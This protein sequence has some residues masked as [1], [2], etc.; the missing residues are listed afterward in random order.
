MDLKGTGAIVEASESRTLEPTTTQHALAPTQS[1]SLFA[2]DIGRFVNKSSSLDSNSKLRL[3]KSPWTP[4]VSYIFPVSEKR[5]LKFQL[6]W[7]ARF[8]WLSYSPSEDAAFCRFCVL[9]SSETAGKGCHQ[10]LGNLVTKPFRN[11]KDAIECFTAH[12]Q[13]QFHRNC[14]VSAENFISVSEKRQDN[15]VHQLDAARKAQVQENRQKL[16]PIV[17]TVIFCGRQQLALRGTNHSSPISVSDPEPS[18]NDG[19][20][21][22]LL[23]LRARHGDD[24]LKNHLLS[25]AGNA[26]YLSPI[27]QNGIIAASG[28]L[29]QQ[30]IVERVNASPCFSVLADET[31]DVSNTEQLSVCVRY[32]FKGNL[33]ED[34]LGFTPVSDLTG[35]GL[36]SSIL[37]FLESLGL[38]LNKMVGQ[39]YD[40]AAAMSGHLRGV[41]AVIR[42]KYPK[43]LYVHCSAHSLNL[44]ISSV[45]SILAFK[46]FFGVLSQVCSFYHTSPL[47]TQNLKEKI[48]EILPDSRKHTLTGLCETRWVERHDSVVRFLE[49]YRPILRSLEALE[50]NGHAETSAKAAQLLDTMNQSQFVVC[51]HV[52]KELFCLTLPLCKTLQSVDCDL[53]AACRHVET[54]LSKTKEMRGNAATAFTS[55][56]DEAQRF[57]SDLGLEMTRPRTRGGRSMHADDPDLLNHY[58]TSLFIPF[59]DHFT[60]EL[61]QRFVLHQKLLSNLSVLS[62][63]KIVSVDLKALNL[64][65]LVELYGDILPE[66]DCLKQEIELWR[67]KW[68][69]VPVS[70]RPTCAVSSLQACDA[71]FF[72]NDFL[73]LAVLATLP[74]STATPERSF[75]TLRRLKTWLRNSTGE[76]RLSGLALLAVHRD[77]DICPDKVIDIFSGK[78]NRRLDFV[79]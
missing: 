48:N 24:V 73:L 8:S 46:H 69:N 77:V 1:L 50:E 18:H 59:L 31:A 26:T 16:R 36:A 3:L 6:T 28:E 53:A 65:S 5:K 51:L 14:I 71:T 10:R 27:I 54:V 52:V 2:N 49:L 78:K 19:N 21:R 29:L 62:P 12:Q 25:A 67:I 9:F 63:A 7:L 76:E 32:T 23:R 17:E 11:W 43:A 79:L 56:F 42:E 61:K 40:G 35:Q 34:F 4:D 64:E 20:F 72:P 15:I 70:E 22:A 45:C 74:V 58:R 13:A 37:Q 60:S 68:E 38:N 66:P 75:S 41:Q 44:V 30:S 55:I 57:A 47:R 39:G 33:H